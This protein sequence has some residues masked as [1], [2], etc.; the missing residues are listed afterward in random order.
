MSIANA[1]DTH[2]AVGLAELVRRREVSPSELLEE[3]IARASRVDPEL[4]AIVIPMTEEARARVAAGVPD[5]PLAGVPFLLKELVSAYAGVPL[6]GASRLYRDN[7]PDYHGEMVVR[8]LA[9]GLVPFGKTNSSEWGILPTCEP[10][11]YG[12]THNPWRRG[13]TTGGSSG[14]AAAAVAARIVPVAHG[15][16]AG[17]SIRIPASC[18]GVLGLKP[19]RARNPMGPDYSERAHGL[20]VEHV[21]SV[22]VRDSAACLDATEGTEDTAI[23]C[24]PPRERPY[25]EEC[26][27]DPG[28]L[29]IAFTTQPLLPGSFDA[30]CDAAVRDAAKL[31]ESLGHE[32][33]EARPS[34]DGRLVSR[35]FFT[36]YCAG[37]AG[38]LQIAERALSRKPRP[39]DVETTTW[40]MGMIGRTAFSAG[41]LS[42]AFRDLHDLA[43]AVHR[44]HRRFDVLLT[45]TLGKAPVAHGA[46]AAKGLEL[47]VQELA[48]R[49]DLTPAL[50]L[51]GLLDQ[52]IDRAFAFAPYTPIANVSGQPSMSV[53]LHWRADG[54]PIGVCLTAR[55][56][57]EATLFR[58]GTQLEQARPW[59][60]RRPP[61]CA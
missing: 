14:G 53:P 23:Y 49:L 10:E 55:F 30:D 27:R 42:V 43:R 21:L 24:A 33:E 45:P 41:D 11:L 48:A 2:D 9:A 51:P 5:G 32:V 16:D 18:C 25:L 44:F 54:L 58:L 8:Y 13:I 61:I 57:D 50:K 26:G 52:A 17:G 3:A 7:V 34:F 59:K 28:K 56:G 20:G 19:T 39:S 37:V 36:V 22:S 29:R 6:R 38:E 35:A 60:D 12:P 15:G 40:L 31:L 1:Y 4:H 47:R 46:L